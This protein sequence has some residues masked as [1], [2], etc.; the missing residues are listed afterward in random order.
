[1]PAVSIGNGQA[2]GVNCFVQQGEKW[3]LSKLMT[4]RKKEQPY[5]RTSDLARLAGVHPNTVRRYAESGLIPPV[6]R[7][8]KGYRCFTQHHLDCLRVACLIYRNTYPGRGIRAS[9]HQVL[10]SAIAGN[11]D[12]ALQ[13]SF[14]HLAFVQAEQARAEAAVAAIAEWQRNKDTTGDSNGLLIGKVADLLDVTID[15]LHNWERNGLITISHRANN[16]YRLYMPAD[17]QRL[18]VIR[19]LAKAGYSQMAILRM[20]IQL[21]RGT[22]TTLSDMRH[23][24]D[25]P[26]PDDDVYVVTDRWL[27]TLSEQKLV[28]HHLIDLVQTIIG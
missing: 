7:T 25:T 10:V 14:A 27:S 13:K 24:L 5:L 11:W 26:R 20:L 1:M 12:T 28:A 22:I 23:A 9:A 18:R 15:M 21:D 3:P 4:K 6:V 19:A 8:P 17:I 2:T 16:G